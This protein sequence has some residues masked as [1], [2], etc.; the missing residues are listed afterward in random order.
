VAERVD[1]LPVP[2]A[3]EGVGQRVEHFG[4]GVQGPLPQGVGVVGGDLKKKGRTALIMPY[5]LDVSPVI[6]MSVYG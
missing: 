2:F 1:D 3:P 4:A 5:R 6:V